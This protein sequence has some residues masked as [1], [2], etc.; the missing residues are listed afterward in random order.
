MS[1]YASHQGIQYEL[2][3]SSTGEWQWAFTP[4]TGPRRSGRVQGEFQFAVT[5]IQR[6]IEVWH[7]MNRNGK[8]EAA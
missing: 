8:S 1:M 3:E 6:A 5:V 7:L 4:P 2:S